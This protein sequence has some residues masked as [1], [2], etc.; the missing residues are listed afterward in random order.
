MGAR[1]YDPALGR[2][3]SADPNP[4]AGFNPQT[5][6]RY[7]YAL[8]GPPVARDLDG[9]FAESIF[10]GVSGGASTWWD[11]IRMIYDDPSIYPGAAYDFLI[12]DD[13]DT[14]LYEDASFRDRLVAGAFLGT[15]IIPQGRIAKLG[16]VARATRIGARVAETA[17]KCGKAAR[18]ALKGL[19]RAEP[20]ERGARGGGRISM[21]EAIELG[22]RHVDG[23]GIMVVTG[24][25]TNFQ[26]R[27]TF[28]NAAGDIE[29]RI[30]RF[31]I[32]PADPHV[33]R[34]GPP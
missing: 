20:L 8:N 31:D 13:I 26:F 34:Y 5:L 11:G 9:L 12:G 27:N 6:N 32:N 24:R 29:T 7:A 22:S 21:D 25:R 10:R 19:R 33:Q 1:D 14:L 18:V 3:T 17:A 15:T 28:E 2:F 16:A 30:G 23:Q 4:G